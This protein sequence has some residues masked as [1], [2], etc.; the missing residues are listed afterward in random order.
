VVEEHR[1]RA[2][3]CGGRGAV[4]SAPA[5]VEEGRQARLE[6]TRTVLLKGCLTWSNSYPQIAFRPWRSNA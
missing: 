3:A 5:V 6:T 1:R 2:H 4:S